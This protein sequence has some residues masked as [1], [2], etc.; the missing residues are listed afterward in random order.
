MSN[1]LLHS[2]YHLPAPVFAA[3]EQSKFRKVVTY[4]KENL[5]IHSIFRLS[6]Y[7]Y[8][9]K[10]LI[11][12]FFPLDKQVVILSIVAVPLTELSYRYLDADLEGKRRGIKLRDQILNQEFDQMETLIRQTESMWMIS[13]EDKAKL[14]IQYAHYLMECNKLTLANEKIRKG[15]G[16]YFVTPETRTHLYRQLS[17]LCYLEE[18]FSEAAHICLEGL[19]LKGIS[20]T[21]KIDLLF[22]HVK[23]VLKIESP[24]QSKSLTAIRK[25][26]EKIEKDTLESM[27]Q[28]SKA[29]LYLLL[30]LLHFHFN[31]QRVSQRYAKTGLKLTNIPHELKIDLY[32]MLGKSLRKQAEALQDQSYSVTRKTLFEKS[33]KKLEKCLLIASYHLVKASIY[34]EICEIYSILRNQ[35]RVEEMGKLGC[36]LDNISDE[37]RLKFYF[38]VC[39]CLYKNGD[40]NELNSAKNYAKEGLLLVVKENDLKGKLYLIHGKILFDLGKTLKAVNTFKE[41]LKMQS[42]SPSIEKSLYVFLTQGLYENQMFSEAEEMANEGLNR[43]KGMFTGHLYAL[44]TNSLIAQNKLIKAEETTKQFAIGRHFREGW[45]HENLWETKG[46]GLDFS[47]DIDND[48]KIYQ[49]AA[50]VNLRRAQQK[51]YFI[52]P[53][54]YRTGLKL[55]GISR[56]AEAALREVH[57]N[58]LLDRKEYAL[59]EE[60]ARNALILK[61]EKNT[62]IRLEGALSM[63]LSKQ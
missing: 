57:V 14:L 6:A 55:T 16:L 21:T 50:Y 26:L 63:A 20:I 46:N 22:C 54:V 3:L 33:I 17:H 25:E 10:N 28:E 5:K 23:A 49:L 9:A 53:A 44:L 48:S 12:A 31:T 42:V 41:G 45:Y 13:N 56:D 36:R 60:E 2:F 8:Y 52:S 47:Y 32:Q 59:A 4:A 35:A 43:L 39:N 15:L 34:L 58:H 19:S 1:I 29:T 18:K 11:D 30:A 62:R 51:P 27:S 7:C 61:I 40:I 38:I 37:F 24:E